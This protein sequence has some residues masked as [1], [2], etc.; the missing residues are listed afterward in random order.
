MKTWHVL[1]GLMIAGL[2][3]L[4]NYGLSGPIKGRGASKAVVPEGSPGKWDLTLEYR[5]GE[6]ACFVILGDH[7]PIVD[8]G[9][10]VRDD[11]NNLVAK[12]SG[13][14]DL[15]AVVWYPPEDGKYT[16][17]VTNPNHIRNECFVVVR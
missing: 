9:I 5:G 17:T 12:D 16:I 3:L 1:A 7:N 13:K 2:F 6:R 15:A 10:E 4:P 14:G 11:K 8:L